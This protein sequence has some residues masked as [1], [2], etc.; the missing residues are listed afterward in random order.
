MARA[1]IKAM[2]SDI[3]LQSVLR[4]RHLNSRCA[5]GEVHIERLG[6]MRSARQDTANAAAWVSHI[7]N[8]AR[9]QV[10]VDMHA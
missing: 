1:S 10:D 4:Y 7:I 5:S 2:R 3:E 6:T 9:D 8:V